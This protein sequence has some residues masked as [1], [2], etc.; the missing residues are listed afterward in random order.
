MSEPSKSSLWL[1]LAETSVRAPRRTLA[2]AV[3][4]VLLAAP[5]LLRLTLRTDGHALV[6]L[7]DPAVVYDSQVRA[8]FGLRDPILVT[9]ER[10]GR[11]GAYDLDV[12]RTV[13]RLTHDFAALPRVVPQNLDSLATEKRDRVYPGT[14][15]FR[16]FLDPLPEAPEELAVYREDLAAMPLLRG[17]L[18][19]HD[20]K[21]VAILVGAPNP[22]DDQGEPTADRI[23]LYR[24]LANRAAAAQV[25]APP[26]TAIEIVGAPVAEALLGHHILEDLRFLVP[27]SLAV[28]ALVIGLAARSRW[29]AVIGMIKI[30][31]AVVWTF[32]VMGWLGVP[33]YLTTA[34]LPV[35]LT[36]IGLS[37]EIHL[38]WRYRERLA[39]GDTQALRTTLGELTG[40]IVLTS[41]TTAVGLLSFVFSPLVAVRAFG[42]F[43]TLGVLFCLAW[44]LTATPALLVL[45]GPERLR[46]GAAASRVSARGPLRRML[47]SALARPRHTL[48][49]LGLVTVGAALGVARLEVQDSWVDGFAPGSPFRVATER[50]DQRF[51]GTHLLL[52][53]FEFAPP[54]PAEDDPEDPFPAEPVPGLHDPRVL[55]ALGRFEAEVGAVPGVGA[56]IGPAAQLSTVSFLRYARRPE[57]R[58][59]PTSSYEIGRLLGWYE[60]VRG[61]ERRRQ[62]VSD[63]GLGA[64]VTLFLKDANYQQVAKI[65]RAVEAAALRHVT[66]PEAAL[67]S[68]ARLGFAGDIAVSQA[69]IPAIVRSQVFSLGTA[70]IGALLLV[71]AV[72]RSWRRA[73]LL[74]TP[75]LAAVL[76]TLGVMGWAGIPLGVATSMFCSITLGIG[77]DYGIHLLAVHRR[78]TEEGSPPG[79]AT[80]LDATLEAGPAILV[81]MLA[82]AAGFGL[83]A[84]SQVPANARL[85]LVVALALGASALLTLAGLGALLAVRRGRPE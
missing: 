19:S 29:G 82:V 43:G 3:L 77:I 45:L 47:A 44:A 59:L 79:F 41:L 64:V 32:G 15:D 62:L 36:P 39:E 58:A 35:I 8:R 27:A 37:D 60:Q 17:T 26:D 74:A 23:A 4:G 72:E 38:L 50:I 80:A 14:L 78:R 57:R 28:L 7:D 70:L 84:F 11:T 46:Q 42:V 22:L 69:M 83:L 49:L 1:R 63:D 25:L 54:R 31:A 73:L 61:I 76:W 6:P 2:F 34:V 66:G 48:A 81:D 12:L 20:Q 16:P 85:G 24:D 55:A 18:L 53:V 65:V 40:P 56:A 5:G 75:V 33:V 67:P 68:A 52:A 21:A 13:E 9:V 30:G 10:P 51:N 71:A